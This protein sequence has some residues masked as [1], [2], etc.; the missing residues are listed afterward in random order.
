MKQTKSKVRINWVGI[1]W[2]LLLVLSIIFF[3]IVINFIIF[4]H[5]FIFPLGLILFLIVA[6]M[7]ILSL[8]NSKHRSVKKNKKSIKKRIVTAVNCVLCVLLAAG[9][10]YVPILQSQMKG[11]FVEPSETQEIEINA[12]VMTSQY[13]SAHP[14]I[15]TNT[16]TSTNLQDYKDKKFITQSKVDQDN[17]SYALENIQKQLNTNELNIVSKNDILSSVSALYAGTGDV[18]LMNDAYSATIKE[19]TGY[20]NF[21]QDTQILYTVVKTVQVEQKEKVEQNYTNTLFMVFIAGSDSRDSS[22]EYYTRTDVDLLIAV[23]PVTKQVLLISIPR[24]WYVKNPA[25]GGG[26]DKLTHLGNSGLQNTMDGLNEEFGIDYIKDYF[27]VNFTTFYNIVEAI[28]GI[29]INNPYTFSLDNGQASD[30]GHGESSGYVF[31]EGPLHLN[32]DQALSYVRERYNLPNGDYGRNE[33]QAIVLQAIIT[34]LTSKEIITSYNSLLNNLQGNFLTSISS[35]SIYSLAQM[36]LNDSKKWSFIT[37][38]LGG[39]GGNDVTAS[40]G[41]QLLYV[42][43]PLT[44]QVEFVKQQMTALMNGTAITQGVMPDADGN[45]YLPN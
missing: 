1:T 8:K 21:D 38:H 14:D 25:L 11:V 40:M 45:V 18:M 16:E 31:E 36:Q 39:Q 23:D 29:D 22:L 9:T 2:M 10:I 15:F 24:D 34:K 12:Y 42:S 41:S 5:K 20:E 6:I 17:Q 32:G 13:K 26:Y 28:G 30:T 4:P 27:E 19:V 37:Y 43:Y 44:T 7:G 3:F 33:H 35:D